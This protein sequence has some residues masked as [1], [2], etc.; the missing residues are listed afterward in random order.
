MENFQ[1]WAND[2]MMNV[3]NEN[4]ADGMGECGWANQIIEKVLK[5]K[6]ILLRI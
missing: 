5:N 6:L 2:E 3:K 4:K 1:N